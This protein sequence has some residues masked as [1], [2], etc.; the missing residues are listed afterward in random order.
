ML[1]REEQIMLVGSM[2]SGTINHPDDYRK[3]NVDVKGI[4]INQSGE[5]CRVHLLFLDG[6]PTERVVRMHAS[7]FHVIS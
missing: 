4:V 3:T 7:H 2:I 1:E 5:Q 6:K